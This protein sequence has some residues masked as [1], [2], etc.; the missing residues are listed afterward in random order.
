[1]SKN[2]TDLREQTFESKLDEILADYGENVA[3]QFGGDT[4]EHPVVSSYILEAKQAIVQL[5]SNREKLARIEAYEHIRLSDN[6]MQEPLRTWLD[7]FIATLRKEL[8]G[9]EPTHE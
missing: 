8:D 3:D 5:I 1:M 6:G 9:E 2:T 4:D 7:G